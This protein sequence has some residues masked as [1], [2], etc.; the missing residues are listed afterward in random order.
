MNVKEDG[1]IKILHCH[2]EPCPELD[3]GSF[4]GLVGLGGGIYGITGRFDI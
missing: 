1:L 2:P 4:Q 3:S